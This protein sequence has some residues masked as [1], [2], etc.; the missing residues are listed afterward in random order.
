MG[1][2]VD[3]DRHA[4]A[5]GGARVHVGEVAPV[6]VGVDLEHRAGA[7]GRREHGVEVDRVGRAALDQ[8]ARGVSDRVDERMLDGGDHALGHRLLAHPEGRVHA[9]DDPVEL[10]EQLVLVV[11]RA[12]GQDVDLAAGQQLGCPSMRALA[13]CTQLD[14]AAQLLR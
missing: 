7:R 5:R 1:V 4:R 13:S 6:G 10:A 9:R 14:L 11:E 2:G 12:V 3:H 8:P